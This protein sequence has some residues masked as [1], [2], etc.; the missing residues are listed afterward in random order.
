[1][2]APATIEQATEITQ[3]NFPFVVLPDIGVRRSSTALFKE[4]VPNASY[5]SQCVHHAA[6]LE[7][8]SV[9]YVVAKG[10]MHT[11][12]AIIYAV[13]LIFSPIVRQNYIC[14]IDSI[15]TSCFNWIGLSGTN[16]PIKYDELLKDSQASDLNSLCAHYNL[17]RALRRTITQNGAPS[18][19]CRQLRPTALIFWN[20]LKGIVDTF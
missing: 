16:I 14:G 18:P 19:P 11:Q 13:L 3:R 20:Y 4:L 5:R 6:V 10:S 9:L 17:G 12:G 2:T 7:T 15:R 8:S 1:M